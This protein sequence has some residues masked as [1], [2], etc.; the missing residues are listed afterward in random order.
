MRQ[1]VTWAI[2]ILLVFATVTV[3]PSLGQTHDG[4]SRGAGAASQSQIGPSDTASVPAGTHVD[5]NG[6]DSSAPVEE[7]P[8]FRGPTGQGHSSATSVPV[9]WDLQ[10]NVRWKVAIPGKGWSS[11]IVS[12][13]RVYLTTAVPSGEDPPRRQSLRA[14]CLDIVTGRKLWD[15]EVF[16]KQL[17]AGEQLNP[18]NSYASPTP[19]TDG[20]HVFVHFGPDGTACLDRDGNRVWINDSLR[21]HPQHGAGGSPIF[22]G[23]RLVFHCDGAEDPS[24]VALHRDSGT[25]AWR[26]SRPPMP[27]PKWSFATPLQIQV[28]DAEQLISPAAHM[29]CSYDPVS[30]AELWRVQ[31]PNKWSIVP[32]PVYSHGLVF[33]CTGYDGRAELLAIRPT[34]SGD[35]TDSHVAWRTDSNVPQIPS[36]LIVGNEIFLL[37]DNGIASCRDV[38]TGKPYWRHRV[39]GDYAASPVHVAGR[40]LLMSEQGVCTVIEAG[41]EYRELATNDLHEP[42][43]ASCA[44]VGNAIIVRTAGH[45]Y[46]ID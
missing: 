20:M 29:V 45:L 41:R 14:L 8:E 23:S 17:G 26:V 3:R 12:D 33:V 1:T 36:P 42:I 28:N 21:Y 18:K 40:I 32:R 13:G 15:A 27:S 35:V 11:P 24:V 46:R 19:V 37:S 10:N 31:Y 39:A 34:G 2:N 30:G 38:E 7:W 5:S 16:V 9:T 4:L 6:N 43:L 25:V 44:V 22:S